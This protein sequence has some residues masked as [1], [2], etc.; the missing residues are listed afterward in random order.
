MSTKLVLRRT[1]FIVTSS[2]CRRLR[3]AAVVL[4]GSSFRSRAMRSTLQP[5]GG[6]AQAKCNGR[7]RM[8]EGVLCFSVLVAA[9]RFLLLLAHRNVTCP[10]L[11][12]FRRSLFAALSDLIEGH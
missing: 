8:K 9:T 3:N 12:Q 10:V 1:I 6:G 7:M 2:R 5:R 11:G 4:P